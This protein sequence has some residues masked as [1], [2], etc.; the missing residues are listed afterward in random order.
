M[1]RH[2]I[3]TSLLFA[4]LSCGVVYCQDNQQ[5]MPREDVVEVPAIGEGL[6]VSNIFQTNMVLQSVRSLRGTS[7]TIRSFAPSLFAGR[8]SRRDRMVA[9]L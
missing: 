7:T 9:L 1:S 8:V 6:C 4:L 2:L 5:K 3:S